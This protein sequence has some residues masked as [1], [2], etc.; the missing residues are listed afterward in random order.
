[1]LKSS[2]AISGSIPFHIAALFACSLIAIS[3]AGCGSEAVATS[4][5]VLQP[6]TLLIDGAEWSK[7]D[8][9]KKMDFKVAKHFGKSPIL[10][11][12]PLLAGETVCY[13]NGSVERVYWLS[14]IEASCQWAMIEFKGSRGGDLV[15]GRGEPF[16]EL[17]TMDP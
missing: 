11:D 17:A 3:L 12:N 4:F 14:T 7:V 16:V 2:V 13:T 10:A 15:E 9:S 1:M 5:K 6:E 8:W